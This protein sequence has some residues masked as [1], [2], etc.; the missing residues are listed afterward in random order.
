MLDAGFPLDARGEDGATALHAAAYSG[1]ADTVRLLLDR[2][3]GIE[4]R[5][6]SW[7]STPLD[8]AAVGSGKS[9]ASTPR[10]AGD[11]RP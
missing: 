10:T 7:D 3:A 5:D 11:Y 6:L 8:W 9:A 1:N 2:G 4:A